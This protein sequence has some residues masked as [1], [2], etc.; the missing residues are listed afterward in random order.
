MSSKSKKIELMK[1]SID[2]VE[3]L[4]KKHQNA[5]DLAANAEDR[6]Q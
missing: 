1:K 5:L 2:K 3:K 6:E 4:L